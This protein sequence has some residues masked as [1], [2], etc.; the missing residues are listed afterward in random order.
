MNTQLEGKTVS[1]ISQNLK[2]TNTHYFVII[3]TA[4]GFLVDSL[5]LYIVAYAMPFMVTEWNI[6]AVTNGV[7]ASAGIW[8]ALIG[9]LSWGPRTKMVARSNN[10]WILSTY[11]SNLFHNEY[12]TI[13]GHSL[14]IRLLLRWSNT[15]RRC[16]YLGNCS[17]CNSGKINICLRLFFSSRFIVRFADIAFYCPDFWLESDVYRWRVARYLSSCMYQIT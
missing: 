5:D 11:R 13:Y 8:G 7:L 12:N 10:S 16:F 17:F 3:C 4:L 6:D 9:S 2:L 15:D 14:C 1:G